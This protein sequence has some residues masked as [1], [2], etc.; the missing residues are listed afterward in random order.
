MRRIKGI[1]KIFLC[2]MISMNCLGLSAQASDLPKGSVKIMVEDG[3]NQAVEVQWVKIADYENG[4][5][6]PTQIM[7]EVGDLNGINTANEMQK[8]CESLDERIR[9]YDK[10]QILEPEGSTIIRNLEEGAYFFHFKTQKGSYS[11]SVVG[12][13]SYDEKQKKMN[14]E[15]EIYPKYSETSTKVVAPQT[16]LTSH[17]YLFYL[18]GLLLLAVAGGCFYF[19][20]RERTRASLAREDLKSL[21]SYTSMLTSEREE[22]PLYRRIDFEILKS[23]NPDIYGWIYVPGTNIDQPILIGET[24]ETYLKKNYKKERS[25][26]GAVFA[27]ADTKKDLSQA[28]I[29]LFAHNMK[30]PLMFGE[31]KQYKKSNYASKHEKM[32]LYTPNSAREYELISAYECS[33]EDLTFRH[34][35]EVESEEFAKLDEH[36]YICN[37]VGAEPDERKEQIV[38]LSCCSENDRKRL[39]MTVHFK[40]TVEIRRGE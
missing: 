27:F 12:I 11:S 35:M 31:L 10:S 39:R 19:A 17:M 7:K 13:P 28:H 20:G 23:I 36:I 21:K 6:L 5:F 1:C 34:Q 14:Y 32:Y 29:C 22:N 24:D 33:K 2:G 37:T 16:G 26:T 25:E 9:V 4:E 38:T 40:K 3:R 18:V 30:Q 8:I 15:L